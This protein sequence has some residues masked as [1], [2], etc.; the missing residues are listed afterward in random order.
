MPLLWKVHFDVDS[1]RIH[2]SL[3]DVDRVCGFASFLSTIS[4]LVFADV[5]Q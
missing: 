1:L 2:L 5:E 3:T 4:S